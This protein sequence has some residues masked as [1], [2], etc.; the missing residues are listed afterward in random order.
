MPLLVSIFLIF[1][2]HVSVVTAAIDS[3]YVSFLDPLF[4]FLVSIE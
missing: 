3:S 1:K 2:S 4:S